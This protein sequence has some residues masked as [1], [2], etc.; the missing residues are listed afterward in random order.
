MELLAHSLHQTLLF[1]P[2]VLGIYMSYSLA[3][4]TDLTVEGS[5]VLGA[6]VYAQSLLYTGNGF[7]SI[8]AGCSAGIL[9]GGMT[10]IIQV[11]NRLNSLMAGILSLFILQSLNILVL[12]KPN[13]NLLSF[14][15]YFSDFRAILILNL[16]VVG[17]LFY[18]NRSFL[19][20]KFRGLGN[21]QMLFSEL[22]SLDFYKTLVLIISNS[23]A[24]LSGVLTASANGY[25]DIYMGQGTA[26]IGIGTLILGREVKRRFFKSF[27]P[28]FD[29]VFCLGG[30][31][32]YYTLTHILLFLGIDTLI[33]KLV[34]GLFLA[35]ILGGRHVS[36]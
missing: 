1:L 23:L 5:F 12:S 17:L 2:L 25:A 30:V 3:K 6:A 22:Y 15:H 4:L 20:L 24:A 29:L 16:T 11:R 7:L 36:R 10:G 19:G 35:L 31:F 14:S 18:L 34:I 21:N 13:I 28:F 9:S 33:M 27:H 26:I 8:I 32:I